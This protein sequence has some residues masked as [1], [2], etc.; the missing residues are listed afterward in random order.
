MQYVLGLQKLYHTA[1]NKS[2]SAMIFRVNKQIFIINTTRIFEASFKCFLDNYIKD[3]LR[4]RY[5]TSG[6]LNYS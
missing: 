1:I 6:E 3:C 2:I 4:A 5:F